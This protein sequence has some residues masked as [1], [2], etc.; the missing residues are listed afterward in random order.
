MATSS[1]NSQYR[2]SVSVESSLET[3]MNSVE[4]PSAGTSEGES[5]S[6]PKAASLLDK[7]KC[8]SR[9]DLS[10]DRRIHCNQPP[11]GKKRSAGG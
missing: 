7:L 5:E 10:R 2:D 11:K 3:T 6:D 4:S 9:S 8:P 1:S